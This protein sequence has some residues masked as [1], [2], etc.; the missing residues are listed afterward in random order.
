MVEKI[1]L[2]ELLVNNQLITQEQ[3]DTAITKQQH[4]GG[5]IGRIL[6]ELGYVD[7]ATLFDFLAQHLN[8]PF[9]DLKHYAL[10]ADIIRKLPEVLARRFRAIALSEDEECF[11]VGMVDPQDLF[12]VDEI[13]RVLK[14]PI[15]LALVREQSL[16]E[17]IDMIYRRTEE[18]AGFAEEL[19]EELGEHD[20]DL[21]Q[22]SVGLAA[23][24]VPVVKLLQSLFDDAVQVNAS[25]IHIEP[26]ENVLRIRQRIDGV[27]YENVMKEKRIAPAL[28]LRLKLMAGLNISEK[29]LPQD[30]R[31]SLKIK[32]RNYDVRLS[33]LPIQF[34]ESV[35]M[36][37]LNQSGNLLKLDQIGMPADLLERLKKVIQL[38]NGMLLVTGPTGSGK[39]TTL[40]SSLATLNSPENKIITVEDPVEYRISRINQVQVNPKV[41]LTFARVL[42][43]ILR[44]DP[45]IVMVGEIRDHETASIALRAS[46]TGHLVLATMHTNDAI[47][48]TVRLIDM[49]AES[50]LVATALRA[51]ISQRLVRRVCTSCNKPYPLTPQERAWVITT[52]GEKAVDANYQM[53][54][55]CSHC[56]GTGYSGQHAIFEL[57]D[58]NLQLSDA[59]RRNDT[60]EFTRLA[61]VAPGFIPLNVA[62][63]ELA[64]KGTTSIQEV[65]RVA[66]SIEE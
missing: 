7:E 37:L 55:G 9:I 22:L 47:S 25:D 15:K 12:A 18:I 42:R 17:T 64:M 38:P 48:S 28:T 63:L 4:Y 19:S 27:L 3:L 62:G 59:L 43:S 8:I 6:V 23:A 40:Y 26:D 66:G 50:Y 11:T 58:M 14:K 44:Q 39:T 32:G 13:E 1:R 29:R 24:D 49:G 34:G 51:V 57:L 60:S 30:G 45:D 20:F 35:V 56:N 65:L 10:N 41:D 61:K 53:G 21:A 52:G 46:M 54:A 36:R 16:L 5:K 2:G 31:F 33:T